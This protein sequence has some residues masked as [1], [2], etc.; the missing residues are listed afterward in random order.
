ML[1]SKE[2]N[3]YRTSCSAAVERAFVDHCSLQIPADPDKTRPAGVDTHTHTEELRAMSVRGYEAVPWG[4]TVGPVL[5]FPPGG[6]WRKC[7]DSLLHRPGSNQR[8][9]AKKHRSQPLR[10]RRPWRASCS[11]NVGL[12]CLL[13]FVVHV[14]LYRGVNFRPETCLVCHASSCQGYFKTRCF[15][16]ID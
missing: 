3:L 14:E 11:S 6:L 2:G 12:N 13:S 15:H 5:L 8:G 10:N 9:K 1:S 16:V 4:Q 7:P